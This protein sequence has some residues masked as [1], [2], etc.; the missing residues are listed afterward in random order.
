MQINRILIVG[1][2]SIGK[3][4]L[5]LARELLPAADIRVLRHQPTDDVPEYANGCFFELAQAVNFA[6]QLAVI[7]NPAPY[8]IATAQKLAEAG[9][10][11]LIEKPLSANTHGV[12]QLLETCHKNNIVLCVGYNLRFL[13][14]LQ[15]YRDCLLNNTIGKVLSVRCEI[16]QYLL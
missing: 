5:R 9:V 16:G 6:P 4:H 1:L 7:A 8:H 12:Q 3:R 15:Y 14:S 2:G 13:P 10:H 11:L